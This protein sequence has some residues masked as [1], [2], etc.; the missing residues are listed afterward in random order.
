MTV[1]PTTRYFEI[2]NLIR[3]VLFFYSVRI[4]DPGFLQ[5][6]RISLEDIIICSV[7]SRGRVVNR[8]KY[9]TSFTTKRRRLSEQSNVVL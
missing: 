5:Y 2:W 7:E 3:T 6:F 1:L 9:H 8:H 4:H